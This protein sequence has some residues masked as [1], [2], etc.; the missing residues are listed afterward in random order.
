MNILITGGASGLGE[1][2]TRNLATDA[3]NLI[4]VTYSSS[5]KN[6][7]LLEQELQNVKTIKCNFLN[8]GD[9]S[10]L[11]KMIGALNLDILINNAYHGKF[12]D[13]Y[14]HKTSIDDFASN[15][16]VNI[17]PTLNITQAVLKTFRKQ[18][19]GKIITL[20]TSALLDNPPMGAS[21][22]LAGKAYLKQMAKAWATENV[23]HNIVSNT[24]SPSMLKT[25]LTKEIDER[26]IE[27]IESSHPLKQLLTVEEV[28]ET[29][30]Y[31]VNASHQINGID[32]P[33]NASSLV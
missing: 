23:K 22:Y 4:Y 16:E 2:I 14:F 20:L 27:Q 8:T 3:K 33:L 7:K 9:L 25:N 24:I 26:I 1:A 17:I 21:V 19:N 15:F 30:N 31:L 6:A 10:A 12:I 28:A 32:I 29:V 18:K 5:D 13:T 11:T